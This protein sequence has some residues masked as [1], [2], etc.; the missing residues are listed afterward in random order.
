MS[1][2]ISEI[3]SRM[4]DGTVIIKFCNGY[5]FEGLVDSKNNPKKGIITTPNVDKYE[6]P[7]FERDIFDIFSMIEK[8]ELER[9]RKA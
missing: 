3:T 9:F 4:L 5:T 1:M 7:E 8:K 6:L 2:K